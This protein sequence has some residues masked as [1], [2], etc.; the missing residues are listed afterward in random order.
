MSTF[1]DLFNCR[2]RVLIKLH[3]NDLVS[4]GGLLVG[5]VFAGGLC[6]LVGL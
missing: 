4:F 2:L 5:F 6:A 1:V 3:G